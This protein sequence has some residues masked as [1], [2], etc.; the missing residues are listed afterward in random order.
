MDTEKLQM[1]EEE[2]LLII[3]RLHQVLRP[4]LLRREKK[5]VEKELPQKIEKIIRCPLSA[6]QRTLY[7]QIQNKSKSLQTIKGKVKRVSLTNTV[8]QL[9]KV[10]NHPFLFL[11]DYDEFNDKD[12]IRVSGKFEL[13]DR[14]LP[15]LF[16]KNHKILL[17][18]QMTKLLNV[19]E[20]FLT[21]KKYEYLRLDGNVKSELRGQLVKDWNAPDS[22]YKIFLLSTRAGG[23]GINLATADTVVLYDS[24]WNPQADLQAQDRAHRIGQKK[25][26]NVYRLI[27]KGGIEEKIYQRAVKKLY[28]DA[29]VIQQGRLVEQNTS[30]SKSELLSMITFGAE[31]IFK[32]KEGEGGEDDNF[33]IT[34]EELELILQRGEKK[35]EEIDK[36]MKETCQSNL[37]NFSLLEDAN[38]YE[39]EG[40]DYSQ[41]PTQSVLVEDLKDD[42]N[43]D[44]LKTVCVD[45]VFEDSIFSKNY[46]ILYFKNKN[47]ASKALENLKTHGLKVKF[48]KKN[49]FLLQ[50]IELEI[51]Q[52]SLL[53]Q[54]LNLRRRSKYLTDQDGNT[55]G[56]GSGGGSGSGKRYIPKEPK[57]YDFQFLNEK[58]LIELWKK[59]IS[60]E[61]EDAFTEE[62]EK[63]K[64]LLLNEGFLNWNKKDF[65]NYIKAL[66][67]YGRDSISL[68]EIEGKNKKEI[69]EYSK[70]FLK[71]M[72]ELTDYD[73]I[74]K[75]IL[76]GESLIERMNLNNK[77]LSWKTQKYKNPW[78]EMTFNYGQIKGKQF[79]LE[80]DSFIICMSAQFGYGNFDLIKIEIRKCWEFRFDWFFKSRTSLELQKRCDTLLKLIE[81][82]H[83]DEVGGFQDLKRKIDSVNGTN[84]NT[85]SSKK[86]KTKS[87]QQEIE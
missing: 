66:E 85:S 44:Y 74:Y 15:K 86:K 73:K 79:T 52:N 67:K 5:D 31:E 36:S 21:N 37:L 10:C 50:Q 58:R 11:H 76:K 48:C 87:Q 70:V 28:L 81:K 18:S 41:K 45:Y 17:F 80:E 38:L 75:K 69:E 3:Q 4:F 19:L 40:L 57:Y 16:A 72:N 53:N 65:T 22:P 27:T 43:E 51:D 9:R 13:L 23:L 82:E 63:E 25:P 34:D 30:L 12:L 60:E 61:E 14:I 84:S 20:I 68:I 6:M 26:V 42:I 56:G 47:I 54:D 7:D 32:T 29:V 33:G 8:M 49:D 59:S 71:R 78:F 2:N 62:D 46:S 83:F 24:D 64:E 1:T 39:F 35:F 77:L 55:I